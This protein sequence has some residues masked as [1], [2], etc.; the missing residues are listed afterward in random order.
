MVRFLQFVRNASDF[1]T[2]AQRFAGFYNLWRIKGLLQ[3]MMCTLLNRGFT[4]ARAIVR[5]PLLFIA[6]VVF[7]G[8]VTAQEAGDDLK[9]ATAGNAAEREA[10]K[11]PAAGEPAGGA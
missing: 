11:Q 2:F 10:S 6:L 5:W 9:K 8:D 1:A 7:A 4:R 3:P